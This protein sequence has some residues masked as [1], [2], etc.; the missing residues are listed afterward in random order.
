MDFD[1]AAPIQLQNNRVLLRPL[2]AEDAAPL[3]PVIAATPG[4]TRFSPSPIGSAPAL[5]AFIAAALEERARGIRYPFVVFDKQAGAFAGST[6]IAAVSNRDRRLEIG[7]TWIGTAFQ[8]SGLN[9]ACKYLL[10]EHAFEVLEFERV[11]FKTDERNTRS[12]IAI[13]KIGG[14]FE[15]I[16]RSHT[17]MADGYRRNTV[18][19]SILKGEWPALKKGVFANAGLL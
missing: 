7:W 5:Q 18:Y 10:L 8:Q 17:L 11:E 6:S 15:G 14:R 19:Y 3:L 9:R 16:L 12:R 13:Q 1:F 2:A 4:L